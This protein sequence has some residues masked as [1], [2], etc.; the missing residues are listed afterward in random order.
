MGPLTPEQLAAIDRS[1]SEVCE[2][3][4]L[5]HDHARSSLDGLDMFVIQKLP[6]LDSAAVH[7]EVVAAVQIFVSAVDGIYMIVVERDSSNQAE[8]ELPAVLPHQLVKVD[9]HTFK[10]ILSDQMPRLEKKLTAIQVH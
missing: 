5:S 6:D 9:L 2:N 3:F 10:G 4:S 1:T 7:E 8:D